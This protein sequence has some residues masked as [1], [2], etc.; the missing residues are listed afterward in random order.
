MMG[1]ASLICE[2]LPHSSNIA[3]MARSIVQAGERAASLTRQMLAYSGRGQFA[4]EPV[5]LCHE[6]AEVAGRLNSSIPKTVGLKLDLSSGLARIEADRGL[7]QQLI[8]NLVLNAA[9]AIGP[10]G[11]TVQVTTRLR[12]LVPEDYGH[13]ASAEAPH[14]GNYICL[15]VRDNGQGMSPQVRERIFEPFFT[16]KFTGRGLGLAAVIGIVRSHRGLIRVESEPGAG[17]LVV[18]MLPPMA[19]IPVDATK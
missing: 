16:T 15:E 18:V 1:N 8:M 2:E 3:K 9:E 10:E 13:V 5:D 11:G 17:T 6:V 14:T 4:V 7:I 19:A 12:A